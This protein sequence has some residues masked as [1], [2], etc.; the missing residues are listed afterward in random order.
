MTRCDH[1]GQAHTGG[2]RTLRLQRV[3][4]AVRWIFGR[5]QA[6]DSGKL[7][8]LDEKLTAKILEEGKMNSIPAWMMAVVSGERLERRFSA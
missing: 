7:A 1:L 2:V 8:P 6:W 3:S 5:V 4:R